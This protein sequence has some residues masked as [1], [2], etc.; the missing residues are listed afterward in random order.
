MAA[1]AGAAARTLAGLAQS[2]ESLR[3]AAVSVLIRVAGIGVLL[4]MA[5]V[6]VIALL[7]VGV[8]AFV[9]VTLVAL[10][11]GTRFHLAYAGDRTS[12]AAPLRMATAVLIAA[13]MVRW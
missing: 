7:E 13:V 12:L 2:D 11:L 6:G 4:F 1:L 9:P 3:R 5:L 8:L 10:A